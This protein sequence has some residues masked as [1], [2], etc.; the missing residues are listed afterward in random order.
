[1]SPAASAYPTSAGASRQDT[2]VRGLAA[3]W[4]SLRAGEGSRG[5][6]PVTAR[7]DRPGRGPG[8]GAKLPG[9]AQHEG[10]AATP[11]DICYGEDPSGGLGRDNGPPRLTLRHP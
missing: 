10:P 2:P 11:A 1:M 9:G 7:G 6:E 4:M 8:G 3:S 5:G